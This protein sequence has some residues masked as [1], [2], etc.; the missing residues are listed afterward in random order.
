MRRK[1][2]APVP[3]EIV[4]LVQQRNVTALSAAV[5]RL[6]AQIRGLSARLDGLQTGFAALAARAVAVERLV[7]EY[8]TAASGH[9]PSVQE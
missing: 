1:K 9:G 7:I 6:D 2:E 4:D 8:K 5:A 3:D